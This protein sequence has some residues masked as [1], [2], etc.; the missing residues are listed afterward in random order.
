MLYETM[1]IHNDWHRKIAIDLLAKWAAWSQ[2]VRL[3]SGV[4]E[5]RTGAGF[6]A[7]LRRV[8]LNGWVDPA[9]PIPP[10]IAEFDKLIS[11][12]D[13]RAQG[14][15]LFTR[16]YGLDKGRYVERLVNPEDARDPLLPCDA[17][18]YKL[19][20]AVGIGVDQ[21]SG[22]AWIL[23]NL[24][25]PPPAPTPTDPTLVREL[26]VASGAI[27]CAIAMI[28]EPADDDVNHGSFAH[29]L[30]E[31]YDR[32]NKVLEQLRDG[33]PPAPASGNPPTPCKPTVAFAIALLHEASRGIFRAPYSAQLKVVEAIKFLDNFEAN[34][35]PHDG[36]NP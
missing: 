2:V 10:V 21:D 34:P 31:A 12:A 33:D 23:A 1:H 16:G 13:R 17:D 30:C 20:R 36:T 25:P 6:I 8:Q 22:R 5:F 9:P 4:W 19:A 28:G 18:A 15:G 24:D 3:P 26:A 32:V 7:R 35:E 29:K 11:S 14:W 27:D